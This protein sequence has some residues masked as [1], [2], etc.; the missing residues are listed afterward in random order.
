[1]AFFAGRLGLIFCTAALL[2]ALRGDFA[3][4]YEQ[5]IP[6]HAE[7]ENEAAVLFQTA[8]VAAQRK[9][10]D[11]GAL[12]QD[13][14]DLE[15]TSQEG[16]ANVY[17][18]E[19]FEGSVGEPVIGKPVIAKPVITE[20]YIK[21]EEEPQISC[22]SLADCLSLFQDL[23]WFVLAFAAYGIW[24]WFSEKEYKISSASE[25]SERIPEQASI[26][27]DNSS[28]AVQVD[29]LVQA[30]YSDNIDNLRKLVDERSV[31]ACDNVCCCTALH[32]AAH[33]SNLPA[34]E[35]LLARGADVNVCDVWDETPLHFA[36]R[37][38][39]VE[40][41][42]ILLKH[43]ADANACNADGHTPLLVAAVAKKS[44]VCELLLDRGAHTGGADEEDVPP[45]LNS[46]L[47]R[48]IMS[49]K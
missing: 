4:A 46:L 32:M 12:L 21:T 28:T 8:M 11:N 36:A 5:T 23:V 14:I 18:K 7:A 24:R 35:A 40:A 10:P 39:N 1:M 48:R 30:M 38:G 16:D 44:A 47:L 20:L 9:V 15:A 17:S 33:C 43:R 34:A 26:R 22:S 41:C 45:L 49:P 31:N 6:E 19:C 3:A 29:A 2:I 13:D 27:R 37:A 25:A 42:A